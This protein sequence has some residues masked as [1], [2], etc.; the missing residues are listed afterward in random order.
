MQ[1]QSLWPKLLSPFH[2]RE[3]TPSSDMMLEPAMAEESRQ[4]G[5][6]EEEEAVAGV[7]GLIQAISGEG[8]GGREQRGSGEGGGGRE[9]R[10][11]SPSLAEMGRQHS[12]VRASR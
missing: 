2:G 6:G 9:Q 4:E 8:G 3:G 12:I 7:A 11:F 10:G 5:E 1:R